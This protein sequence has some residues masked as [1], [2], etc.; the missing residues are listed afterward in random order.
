VYEGIALS[1]F[2]DSVISCVGGSDF[3]ALKP[4]STRVTA[5]CQGLSFTVS[6]TVEA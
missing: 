1:G 6:V 2:D 3:V 4:G 5:T